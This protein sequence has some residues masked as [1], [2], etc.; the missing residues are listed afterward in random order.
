MKVD[1]ISPGWASFKDLSVAE[2]IGGFIRAHDEVLSYDFDTF[3][4]GHLT[5]LGNRQDVEIAKEYIGSL[6]ANA[7][8]ALGAVDF[9]TIGQQTGFENLYLLFDTFF[10]TV[11][12]QCADATIAQ[13]GDK[14]GGVDIF[15]FDNCWTMA[16]YIL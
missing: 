10:D 6:Q 7:G 12:Q 14:L 15:A 16:L 5:R 1:M 9:M 4:G 13:W 3:M 11:A 2:D 8:K